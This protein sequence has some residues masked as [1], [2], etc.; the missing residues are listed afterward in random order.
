MLLVVVDVERYESV[1]VEFEFELYLKRFNSNK[2]SCG[3]ILIF[4]CPWTFPT[5]STI[6]YQP[7]I[8]CKPESNGLKSIETKPRTLSPDFSNQ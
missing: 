7:D 2:S 8:C 3:T 4:N 1:F 6:L 5:V